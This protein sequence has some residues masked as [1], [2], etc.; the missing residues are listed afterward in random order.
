MPYREPD[1]RRPRSRAREE[2]PSPGSIESQ[3]SPPPRYPSDSADAGDRQT[4]NGA[5]EVLENRFERLFEQVNG[6]ERTTPEL[7]HRLVSLSDTVE[8]VVQE[9]QARNSYERSLEEMFKGLYD[10]IQAAR[11]DRE[12]SELR[13]LYLDL[14]HL[15]DRLAAIADTSNDQDSVL[16]ARDEVLE[17]LYRRGVDLITT[18]SNELDSRLQHVVSVEQGDDPGLAGRVSR[19]VRDGFRMG[20]R[21]LRPQSVVVFSEVGDERADA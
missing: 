18:P 5:G 16:S 11:V 8:R 20:E 1:D 14:I 4:Q 7:S 17:V 3:T 9:L 21:V 15:T 19:A 10:D 6:L 12:W 2:I 13:P